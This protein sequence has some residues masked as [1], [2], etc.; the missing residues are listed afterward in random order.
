MGG[1][2]VGLLT[3]YELTEDWEVQYKT[4]MKNECENWTFNMKVYMS[5]ADWEDLEEMYVTYDDAGNILSDSV[6]ESCEEED[7]GYI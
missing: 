2:G 3:D 6:I 1:C 7:W 5:T 4:V